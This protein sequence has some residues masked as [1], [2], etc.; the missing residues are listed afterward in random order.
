[1]AIREAFDVAR[2]RLEDHVRELRGDVKTPSAPARARVGKLFPQEG[3]GFL[4]TGDGREVYFHRNSVLGPGF[5]ALKIG[6]EVRFAEEEGV[7]GPQATTVVPA[8]R[9]ARAQA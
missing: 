8:G 1:M 6:A 5:D 2:R 9:R 4:E 7:E 3:Y